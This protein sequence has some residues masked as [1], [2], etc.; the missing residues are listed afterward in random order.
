[1]HPLLTTTASTRAAED[2]LPEALA[3]IALRMQRRG[4]RLVDSLSD[5][6]PLRCGLIGAGYIRGGISRLGIDLEA[7]DYDA[8]E[9]AFRAPD[10]RVRYRDFLAAVEKADPA[11]RRT[12]RDVTSSEAARATLERVAAQVRLRRTLFMPFFRDIDTLRRNRVTVPQFQ[13]TLVRL[14]IVLS[15]RDLEA[16]SEAYAD[17]GDLYYTEFVRDVEALAYPQQEEQPTSQLTASAGK[18]AA[19]TVSTSRET[20]TVRL[21]AV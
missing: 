19:L 8:I 16:L 13:R 21:S 14:N 4:V 12:T 2:V 11:P 10:G 15:E 6:D 5:H 17:G 7:A 1:M 20:E 3:K 18:V 9:A